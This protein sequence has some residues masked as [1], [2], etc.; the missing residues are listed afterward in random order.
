MKYLPLILVIFFLACNNENKEKKPVVADTTANE[1]PSISVQG[2]EKTGDSLAI[3]ALADSIVA[4]L[5][6]RDL[7]KLAS[8]VH[9][10]KGVRFAPYA[11]IDSTDSKHF[12]TDGLKRSK[13]PD[14][15]RWGSYDGSGDPIYLSIKRYFKRFVTNVDYLKAPQRRYNSF[16]GF[17]NSLNNLREF[18]P[19]ASFVEY[20][21]PGFDKKFEGM[22][23]CCLR[24]V[25]EPYNGTFKLTGVV[26]DEWT[27]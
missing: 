24:I 1:N 17:G 13:L 3:Y 7:V 20:Y 23:W 16:V 21:Y 19:A 14:V 4:A 10:E 9:P 8:F 18:F 12:T 5:N 15:H 11:Y 27:I 6:N 26:H 25:I 2:P 22:D